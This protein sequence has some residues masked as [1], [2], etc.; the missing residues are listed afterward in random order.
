MSR[1]APG[2]AHVLHQPR[3]QQTGS[4][5]RRGNSTRMMTFQIDDETLTLERTT[6]ICSRRG[7]FPRPKIWTEKEAAD[8]ACPAAAPSSTD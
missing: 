3:T 4:T 5:N 8:A 1:G 7:E 2:W 6:G